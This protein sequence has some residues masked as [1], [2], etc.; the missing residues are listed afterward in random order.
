MNKRHDNIEAEVA[1]TLGLLD[2]IEPLEVTHHFRVRMMQH[3]EQQQSAR[4][5]RN[6]NTGWGYNRFD[7]RLAFMA[8]L[9]IINL[10]SALLVV[11]HNSNTQV[12]QGIS[13][14]MDNQAYDY[15]RSTYAYYDQTGTFPSDSEA[16]GGPNQ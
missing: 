9:I 4:G 14:V 15:T 2:H 13:E 7:L 16:N 8:I 12:K 1:K 5:I 3:I 11:N 6:F 10:A